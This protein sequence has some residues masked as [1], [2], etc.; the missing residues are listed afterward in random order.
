M[1]TSVTSPWTDTT[2]IDG[3]TYTYFVYSSNGSYCTASSSGPTA[4]LAAPGQAS[5]TIAVL[6]H[7]GSGQY[8]VHVSGLSA[9]GTVTKYQYL[10]S[11]DGT[12][13]DIPAGGWLTSAADLAVYG[14]SIDINLRACRTD[15]DVYCGSP[16]GTETATPINARVTSASCDAIAPALVINNPVNAS[17]V[18]VSVAIGYN[19]STTGWDDTFSSTKDDP[20]P[21]DAIA[22]R[23]KATVNGYPDP[24][25]G[26]FTCTF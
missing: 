5:G 26:E 25:Y 20:V 22:M 13:R 24:G 23:V 17:G 14:Q 9:S 3:E 7:G 18:T 19:L 2:S 6:D 16:S 10:L 21:S 1:A 8:D 12:W 11:T 4:S 15:S